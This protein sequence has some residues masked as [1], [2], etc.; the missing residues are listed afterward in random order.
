MPALYVPTLGDGER[1]SRTFTTDCYVLREQ[2]DGLWPYQTRR[3]VLNFLEGWILVLRW[4]RLARDAAFRR[5]SP[6]RCPAAYCDHPV[7]FGVVE[8]INTAA[9]DDW[10]GPRCVAR[11]R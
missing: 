8:S 7:R 1:S 9:S 3:A 2:L 4:Q 11:S 5:F 10:R 6:P